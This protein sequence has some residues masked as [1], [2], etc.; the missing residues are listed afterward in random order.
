MP[1]TGPARKGEPVPEWLEC[2][3][4]ARHPP[5]ERVAH[6]TAGAPA[7]LKVGRR[8]A[9][10]REAA[11]A[12]RA[13]RALAERRAR[14][15]SVAPTA[16]EDPAEAVRPGRAAAPAWPRAAAAVVLAAE[17]AVLARAPADPAAGPSETNSFSART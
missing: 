12:A 4:A 14:R 16:E 1:S 8:A 9:E 17:A 15:G 7:R 11:S 6:K 10:R 3:W 5:A 2:P 13:E